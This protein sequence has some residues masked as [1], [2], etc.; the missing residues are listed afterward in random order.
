MQASSSMR[1]LENLPPL[2]FL[3]VLL[4]FLACSV[5]CVRI[6]EHSLHNQQ[7]KQDLAELNNIKYGLF[8]VDGWKKQLAD[9]INDE[10]KEIDIRDANPKELKKHVE[11][12]LSTLIDKVDKKIRETNKKTTKGRIKQAIINVLVD[13]ED[14]KKG[15]PT[16]ADAIIKQLEKP[17]TQQQIKGAVTDKVEE[18]LEKTF[19]KQDQT[20]VDVIIVKTLSTDREGAQAKLESQIADE[21][22]RIYFETWLLIALS[23]T[24]FV[25]GGL[26][27]KGRLPAPLY[28]VLLLTLLLLLSAGVTTPMIDLEAK[29]SELSF[30]LLDHDIS[31]K[32]QVLYFQTK[33]ILNVFSIMI[34]HPQVQMKAVGILMVMFSIFFPVLKL[35]SSLLYYYDY[36]GSRDRAWVKFFV[37]KS[38]KWSMTDVLVVAIFMAYIGFNGVISSQLEKL[39]SMADQLTFLATN[40]TALQPGF[41]L[42][43]GYTILAMFLSGYLTREATNAR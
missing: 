1:L 4:I 11:T 16:Y 12:Q 34:H 13:K 3:P 6:I 39:S 41:F 31:F 10:L 40:G 2:R 26:S 23:A 37:I 20:P 27:R 8:S 25:L 33:S 17:K 21:Q 30:T 19:D 7:R 36:K 14:I 29:I 5:L 42:F 22:D 15:I 18:Y 32:N 24:L 38:G 9:I 43:L 28:V 35:I